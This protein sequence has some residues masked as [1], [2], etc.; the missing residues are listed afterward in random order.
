MP[1]TPVQFPTGPDSVLGTVRQ[2]FKVEQIGFSLPAQFGR[3][4]VAAS[5]KTKALAGEA[6]VAHQEF[7]Y[8]FEVRNFDTN[9][10]DLLLYGFIDAIR[11]S[12]DTYL[13]QGPHA[14]VDGFGAHA[15]EP[16]ARLMHSEWGHYGKKLHQHSM[17]FAELHGP[18]LAELFLTESFNRLSNALR[19]YREALTLIP[20]DVALVVFMTVLEGLF[21]TATQELSFRLALVIAWFLEDSK[22]SRLEVFT[23]VKELYTIRSK[24]V[25]GDR[26][27][28]GEEAAAI[29]LAENYVPRSEEVVRKCLRRILEQGLDEF[30][31]KSREL[32]TFFRLVV[33][34]YT[35]KEALAQSSPMSK[36]KVP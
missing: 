23:E 18:R 9:Q 26:V 29:Q 13:E 7:P 21:T 15:T 16:L 17:Q 20:S 4:T 3:V 31:A 1:K 5:A 32:D 6:T 19:L 24:V 10:A 30:A 27:V 25:H 12:S 34:G 22:E 8:F 33:L 28:K 11:L 14:L 2:Y 35:V 36:G